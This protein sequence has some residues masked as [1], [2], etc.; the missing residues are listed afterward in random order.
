MY[1]MKMHHSNMI[2]N[3]NILYFLVQKFFKAKPNRVIIAKRLSS[4]QVI[5]VKM[6]MYM[7]TNMYILICIFCRFYDNQRRIGSI[8][9]VSASFGF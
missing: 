4:G 7:D 6:S 5:S 1:P 2:Y 8:H 3:D 9:S